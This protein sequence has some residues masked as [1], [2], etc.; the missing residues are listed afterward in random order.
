MLGT[1]KQL[2]KSRQ[3]NHL[4]IMLLKVWELQNHL[5]PNANFI[6]HVN[7]VGVQ[8]GVLKSAAPGKGAENCDIENSSK[9][10]R[11]LGSEQAEVMA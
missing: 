9:L 1:C 4:M 11:Q 6:F 8:S 2:L 7:E 5:M 10:N 3:P